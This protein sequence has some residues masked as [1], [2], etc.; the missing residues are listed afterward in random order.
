MKEK[1]GKERE[2][3]KGRKWWKEVERE[4]GMEEEMLEKEREIKNT[5]LITLFPCLEA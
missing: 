3:G 5:N 2:M 1:K 4:E